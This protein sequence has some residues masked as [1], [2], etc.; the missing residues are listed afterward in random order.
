MCGRFTLTERNLVRLA[1]AL[2]AAVDPGVAAAWRP[3]YNLAPGQPALLLRDA[4][5]PRLEAARFGIAPGKGGPLRFNARAETA[6][7]SPAFRAPWAARRCAIPADG[8]YEWSGA[9]RDRRPIWF[10][11][12]AGR[13]LL[14]AGLFEP[15]EGGGLGFAILTTAA[16]G[17]VS[18]LHDRMPVL[19]GPERLA[20]WLSEAALPG[21]AAEDA[22][23]GTPVSSRVNVVANDDEACVAPHVER[24][25]RLI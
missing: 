4:G 19:L 20:A 24:Q 21:P 2:G 11:D 23:A 10:R 14:F 12:P 16:N 25:L 15:E 22:L 5:G 17:P 7:T 18:A 8:F 1:A 13:P 9:A 6:A 3:R